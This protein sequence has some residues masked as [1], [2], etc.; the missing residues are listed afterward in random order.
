MKR[1]LD[2][3]NPMLQQNIYVRNIRGRVQKVVREIYLRTDIPCSSQLCTRCAITAP[4]AVDGKVQQPKLLGLPARTE[5]YKFPH[6]IIPDT[7][8]FFYCMDLMEHKS[9]FYDV[10]IL[11]TVLDELRNQSLPLYNRLRQL[12]NDE[13]KRFYIFHNEFRSDTFVT[14][15]H[16]ESINDRNDRA[17]RTAVKWYQGH[18]NDA[19]K[20]SKN[21]APQIILITDDK[22]NREKARAD[23]ILCTSI[24]SYVEGL[25]NCDELVDMIAQALDNEDAKSKAMK[26]SYPEY[27]STIK[28]LAGVKEGI[29]HQG[30]FQVSAYNFL[31]ASVSTSA[32]DKSLLVLGRENIN[33]AVQGDIVVA[34]L[35]PQSE[36][37]KPTEKIVDQEVVTRNEDA[38][39]DETEEIDTGD[40]Q[41]EIQGEVETETKALPTAKVV[42][43]VRRN[44]RSYVGHIDP[45]SISNLRGRSQQTVFL[46]PMDRRI[47]KIR[48]RT[49]QAVAL[50]GQKIV[51]NIDSWQ[52][53]S[54]YPAG[55]FIRALGEMENKE[56]ET[57]S[58]L[59]EYDVQ[60][61]P[62]P[63]SVLDCLPKE[64]NEWRVPVSLE[65]PAWRG[66][67][68]FRDLLVCSVDPLGCQDIDDALHARL[69]P[70]GNFEVGV[71]IA[72]VSYFVKP[73][74]AMDTEAAARGTTV[75]LVD[76]R[77]DMLPM[78]LG[79]D[80][81]SLKPCVE[82]FAFST[83][84][85]ITK[86]SEILSVYFTKSVIK[87]R[88]A[89]SY[90]QAQ[91]RIDDNSQ[92]DPLTKSMRYLLMLS[93]KLRHKR[94]D[95]G[96]LN[97][98]SP[99]V[100]I[101]VESETSDPVDVETKQLQDTNSLVEEFMLLANISVARKI[102]EVFPDAA[103]LRRHGAPPKSN[104][105]QLQDM[106]RV[107]KN[108]TLEVESSKALADSLDRCVDHREPFFN[109]LLRIMTTRCMLSAEYFCSGSTAATEFR[110]YGLASEIYTHW[111]SPIR[112]YA[113]VVS[114][115]QLAAAIDYELIHPAL[116]NKSKLEHVCKN[117]NYRHRMAQMAGRASVEY[118]VGQVLKGKVV[119]E[120]AFVFRVFKNGFVVFIMKFG[121]E[122]VI[123]TKVLGHDSEFEPEQ[124]KLVIKPKNAEPFDIG[125][126]D[127]CRV[128]ISVVRENAK[129]QPKFEYL[130]MLNSRLETEGS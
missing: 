57:E 118:Y 56:A 98:A 126:F 88:D 33:R 16:G 17:I 102:N 45:A 121:I 124:Y 13:D 119:E 100:K 51:V 59:L 20:G 31:E 94:M 67:K 96:A 120:D 6:Y 22:A 63:K 37:K 69:L 83:I 122:G 29:Y 91:L 103:M 71:H 92:Q 112:R 55:H 128:K 77:I 40:D 110:H 19:V 117:I 34:Q 84:W 79:T 35:L 111:T 61:R 125:I 115:R 75:Y 80:L 48:I 101:Q 1:P 72:D 24:K 28:L 89:F 27:Y 82:R 12:V 65:D 8:I 107:R 43:I 11:Q 62:F 53:T 105:E 2:S 36:W 18:I 113:D 7:N 26:L 39:V 4:V 127:K 58:L 50:S 97:L 109:T 76:K 93:K 81:C 87:S 41:R 85:E 52:R 129:S 23:N 74:T 44:W 78:L 38:E 30:V 60:Y 46:L 66:R 116:R 47:P 108:M 104:F 21:T 5:K 3:P 95:A 99:E 49:R 73:D 90:E 114:H 86:D 130:K 42:G 10:I 70:N 14:R 15:Q 106:L 25:E 123:Y 54:R 32:F 64:G 9:A 68:D